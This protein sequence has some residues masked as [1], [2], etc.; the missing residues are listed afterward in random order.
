MFYKLKVLAL[1]EDRGAKKKYI[2]SLWRKLRKLKVMTG[3]ETRDYDGGP[4]AK[5]LIKEYTVN[6]SFADIGCMWGVNGD[7]SF[8]AEDCGAKRVLAVDT[9]STEEFWREKENRKSAVEF[10]EGDIN[11]KDAV[12]KIG[13]C[14]V[15]FCSGVLYHAPNPLHLLHHLRSICKEVM[16]FS[17]AVIPEMEGVSNTAVFYPYLD[18]KQRNIWNIDGQIRPS[19]SGSYKAEDGYANWFWGMSPSCVESMLECTGF[20]I[21]KRYINPFNATFIC[22]TKPDDFA[23]TDQ[24]MP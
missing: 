6:K 1:K 8:H 17:S 14:D 20:K 9:W 16:I 3:L 12:N 24:G 18:N 7:Y 19:I 13:L 21:D 15:V 2:Q 5:E 22:R 23:A 11:R 10:I 4:G